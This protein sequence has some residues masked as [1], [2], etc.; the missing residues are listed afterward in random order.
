ME[1]SCHLDLAYHYAVNGQPKRATSHVQLGEILVEELYKGAAHITQGVS[2]NVQ[3]ILGNYKVVDDT[4]KAMIK[5]SQLTGPEK[6]TILGIKASSMKPFRG[7][8]PTQ[9]L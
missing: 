1:L 8:P 3:Y 7:R 2:A 6:A 5:Y 9:S 4:L